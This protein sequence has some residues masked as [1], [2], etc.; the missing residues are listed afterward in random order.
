MSPEIFLYKFKNSPYHF[1]FPFGI[2]LHN[3]WPFIA[4][5]Q[6]IFWLHAHTISFKFLGVHY[7]YL[8][9]EYE[10]L[11]LCH[12]LFPTPIWLP[13]IARPTFLTQDIF[14]TPIILLITVLIVTIISIHN[15]KNV[16]DMK[17]LEKVPGFLLKIVIIF[18][19][20]NV[21]FLLSMLQ[22][23]NFQQIS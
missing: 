8:P 11:Q 5:F 4:N 6:W 22:A 1:L 21:D 10:W 2:G 18:L 3:K 12:S 7:L 15:K 20:K 9:H 17:W 13:F 14:F 19:N 23:D 16:P